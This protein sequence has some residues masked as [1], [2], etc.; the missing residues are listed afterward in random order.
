M[1]PYFLRFTSFALCL[2]LFGGCSTYRVTVTQ[3]NM[4]KQDRLTQLEPGMT[5]A[6]VEYLL[7][8]PLLRSPIAPERWDYVLKMQRGAET[9]QER[10][11]TVFFEEG[12]VAR[13]E[14]TKPPK[15]KQPAEADTDANAPQGDE[16][17]TS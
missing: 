16:A 9:L 4:V 2:L 17:S 15:S 7:G 11:V 13:I 14:D 10:R 8:T 5:P 6:Q 12:V 1:R 3:G